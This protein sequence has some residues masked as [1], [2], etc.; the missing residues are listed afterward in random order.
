[1]TTASC[2]GVTPRNSQFYLPASYNFAFY[3]THTRAARSFY[4]AH[5]AHFGIYEVALTKGEDATDAFAELEARIR[6]L[7][8]DPPKFEPPAELIAPQWNPHCSKPTIGPWD[9]A[10]PR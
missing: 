5:V 8:T 10:R 9:D 3:D 4:A 2:T 7:V 1:M 6:R